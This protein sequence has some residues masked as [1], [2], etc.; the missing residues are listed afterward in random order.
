VNSIS[1]RFGRIGTIEEELIMRTQASRFVVTLL[2][3]VAFVAGIAGYGLGRVDAPTAVSAQDGGVW[4]SQTVWRGNLA[5]AAIAVTE[6]L[7]EIDGACL[8]DVDPITTT[9]GNGP[10]GTVYAFIVSWSCSR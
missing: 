5:D 10:E 1:R 2:I 3:V 8:V 4:M 6:V 7:N 9:S